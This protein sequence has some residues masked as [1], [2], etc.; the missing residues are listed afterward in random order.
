VKIG[1]TYS[2]HDYMI[3]LNNN[4]RV[5]GQ[6][7]VGVGGSI[8]EIIRPLGTPG[9]TTGGY[10]VL[11]EAWL[12]DL[13]LLKIT[14][15]VSIPNSGNINQG[16]FVGPSIILG[17]PGTLTYYRYN[18]I[19]VPAGKSLIFVGAVEIHITGDLTLKNLA[20]L[21]VGNPL[22]PTVPASVKIFLDRNLDV[23]NGATINNLS[24][25]PGRFRL[26]GTGQPYQDWNIKNSGD[27]YGVYYGPNANIRTYAKATFYGSVSGHEFIL[28]DGGLLHYDS[29]LSGESE[30]DIGFGIDRLWE[31][32]DFITA[33]L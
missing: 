4:A 6:V 5:T 32:S 12:W 7:L 30:Y 18:N 11:P 29:A 22:D 27:Y 24:L 23:A 17:N 16:N 26:F 33:G 3:W 1:T 19:D 15:P 8:E 10:G 28:F 14:V 2:G 21:Y 9:P 20:A 31:K 25:I 13:D